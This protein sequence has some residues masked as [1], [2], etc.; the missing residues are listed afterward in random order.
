[1]GGE[2]EWMRVGSRYMPVSQLVYTTLREG[3]LSC[4]L[5]PGTRISVAELADRMGVSRT[6]VRDALQRL[7]AEGLIVTVPRSQTRVADL[8][9]TELDE[10]Y[11]IRILLEGP[12]TEQAAANITDAQLEELRRIVREAEALLTAG[13]RETFAAHNTAFHTVIYD[14]VPNRQLRQLLKDLRSRAQRYIVAFTWVPG[15]DREILEDHK[16][17]IEALASRDTA[18]C[19]RLM[20][21]HVR[22]AWSSLQHQLG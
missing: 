18:L 13:D 21:D 11:G 20:E 8:S 2:S 10:L 3:I 19:R 14:A 12:A 16:R 6:P 17:I 7:E 5:A 4:R 22:A 9:M 15:R 1:M